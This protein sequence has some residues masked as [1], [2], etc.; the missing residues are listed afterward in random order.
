YCVTHATGMPADDRQPGNVVSHMSV[1]A[2]TKHAS[3]RRVLFGALSL[4]V[5]TALAAAT[6]AGFTTPAAAA[7]LPA[8]PV[9]LPIVDPIGP[10]VPVEI[11]TV[12]APPSPAELQ[13]EPVE[14]IITTTRTV[15]VTTTTVPAEADLNPGGTSNC[16]L[17]VTGGDDAS[18]G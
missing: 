15:I 13:P 8:E 1:F 5:A 6:M 7:P 10:G 16:V 18:D 14:Q 11:I 3:P 17:Q 12:A 4:V 2:A 9:N